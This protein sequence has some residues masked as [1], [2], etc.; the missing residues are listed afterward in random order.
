MSVPN[1][2][3]TRRRSS[4]NASEG[5]WR[6]KKKTLHKMVRR[7]FVAKRIVMCGLS[8]FSFHRRMIAIARKKNIPCQR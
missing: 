6:P 7:I 5:W 3:R 1:D 8:R 2:E 4:K